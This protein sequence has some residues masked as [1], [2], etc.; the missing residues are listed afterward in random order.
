MKIVWDYLKDKLFVGGITML[1]FYQIIMITIYMGGYSA[2]PKNVTEL[3]VAIVSEDAE[4]GTEFADKIKEELPFKVK[5]DLTLDQAKEELDEHDLSM[6]VHIPADF[7]S[8]LSKLEEQ[9]QLNFYMNNATA[10]SVS[11]TMQTVANQIASE[12]SQQLKVENMQGILQGMQ[13]PEEQASSLAEGAVNKV[14]TNLIQSNVPP[15]GMH[16]SMAPM[17]LTI[18]SYV[19][20]M[21]FSMM[22][23]STLNKLK[24]KHGKWRAFFTLQGLSMGLSL[25]GPL[26]GLGIY[27]A[28]QGYGVDV[29]FSMWLSHALEMFVAI[30][31]TSVITMLLGQ[32]GMLVNM[33]FLL[34]Q[35]IGSGAI[36]PQE[37]LSG[38]FKFF[39]SFSVLH[40][41]VET[42][43]SLLFGGGNIA[44]SISMMGV[45][46]AAALLINMV[47]HKLKAVSNTD[48]AEIKVT[49][50][51]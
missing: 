15:A 25:I 3:T 47:I 31:V 9:V 11:G 8:K 13:V 48:K 44:E 16:N 4:Y 34:I 27:F 10:Q 40:Y 7:T 5:S 46:G 32:A 22:A 49:A 19:G 37:M 12:V 23:V 14:K 1:I 2:I 30:Q 45:I 20:A 18:V 41:S 39:S 21:I 50:A 28:I 36:M 24:S 51:A 26:V 35:V 38:F 29:F 33:P 43:Y 17:F 6:V 42:D